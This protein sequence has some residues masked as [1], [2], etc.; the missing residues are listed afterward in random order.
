MGRIA[1]FRQLE[2]W[3]EAHKLTL[4]VYQVTKS[5]PGEERYGLVPQMRRAAV[6]VPANIVEGFK[7]RGIR[8]KVRFYNVAEG[9]LEELKYF[10]ILC[11]DLGYVDTVDELREQS[12]AVGRLL[13]GLI[14]ST[15]R[16]CG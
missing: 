4:L 16:R 10:F 5:L 13:N 7:R 6:S 2:A 12:E 8:E 14:R 15:E 9:S 11:Q 3:K 1:H